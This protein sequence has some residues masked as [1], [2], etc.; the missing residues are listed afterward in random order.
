MF[1]K[2]LLLV[3]FIL[4]ALPQTF[5]A[6]L[7]DFVPNDAGLVI[8]ANIQQ[9]V[10][11]PEI[12][13]K[14]QELINQQ[15]NDYIEQV[16]ATGFDPLTDINSLVLFMPLE[17]MQRTN[18]ANSNIAFLVDGKFDIDKTI[19][20]IKSKKE[21]ASNILVSTEDNFT[22]IT[23]VSDKGNSKMIFFDKNTVVVGTVIGVA[24]AKAVKLGKIENIKNNKDFSNVIT[25]LNQ[26]A[27]LALAATLPEE[28]R[29]YIASNENAKP[30]ST[31]QYL[32]LDLTKTKDI[33]IN[34][35]GYFAPKTDMEAVSKLLKQFG[36]VLNTTKAPYGVLVDFAKNYKATTEGLTAKISSLVT[37][38]SI[39][40]LI[41]S[42]GHVNKEEKK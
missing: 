37:Q 14:V 18:M 11:I 30:L 33:D 16:K 36:E 29:Q 34:V 10:S 9:I 39:D 1:K 26:N 41:E 8:R 24:N 21:N 28:L 23:F 22:T 25:K 35:N 15:G 38:D 20:S 27:T 42:K 6:D 13:T 31:I 2:F 12:K 19:E 32:S 3:V 40:K 17:K 7:L 4:F 5:A